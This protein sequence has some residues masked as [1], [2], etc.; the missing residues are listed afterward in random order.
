MI[1]L[2]SRKYKQDTTDSMLFTPVVEQ[3]EKKIGKE[4]MTVWARSP[5]ADVNLEGRYYLYTLFFSGLKNFK[6]GDVIFVTST[7]PFLSIVVLLVK[8]FK[9]FKVIFQVQDLYPDLMK[10]LPGKY[11][12]AYRFIY[13]FT[14]ILYRMVDHFVT[15]SDKIKENLISNYKVNPKLISIVENWTDLG[16]I[17]FSESGRK[18]KVIY[19]G[20]IGRAHDY[21]YFLDYIFTNG[22]D[23]KVVIK[24]DNSSKLNVF[25]SKKLSAKGLKAV[26]LPETVEWNHTRYSQDELAAFLG[27]FDYSIVFMGEGFDKVLFPCKIYA[28]FAQLLP[29]IFFGPK[30]SYINQW[31]EVNNLGFHY[32]DMNEK[33]NNLNS[34]RKSIDNLNNQYTIA[35]KLDQLTKIILA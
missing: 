5:H 18:G 29:V 12:L 11:N 27:E 26:P 23:L 24:T 2:I 3:L 15:I 20:N 16:N 34:F 25:N 6:K 9:K 30:D 10:F 22:I 28:S 14:F 8:L 1:H 7:P 4:N 17:A 21:S 13:P 35:V 31:L 32:M 33:Y 19:I